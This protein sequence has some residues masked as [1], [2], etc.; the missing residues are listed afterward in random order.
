[1]DD[2]NDDEYSRSRKHRGAAGF[3]HFFVVI[4]G[5][6]VRSLDVVAEEPLFFCTFCCDSGGVHT[7]SPHSL[8]ERDA[9]SRNL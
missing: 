2:D 7:D 3:W 5:E 8:M 4:Q 6:S 1:M 9:P